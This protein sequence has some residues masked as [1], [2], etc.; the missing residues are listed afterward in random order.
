MKT[1]ALFPAV[2]ASL[3]LA[4]CAMQGLPSPLPSQFEASSSSATTEENAS[5]DVTDEPPPSATESPTPPLAVEERLLPGGLLEIGKSDA[6]LN[7]L[8]FTNHAC[9]YCERFNR[10]HLARVISDFV[11]QGKA[12]VTIVALPLGKYPQSVNA[13][14]MLVCAAK[15]G[16]GLSM[17]GLLF[18]LQG[19]LPAFT[20]ETSQAYDVPALQTCM[21]SPEIQSAVDQQKSWA[22]SLGVSL[23]PTLFLNGEKQTGLPEYADLRGWME[24]ALRDAE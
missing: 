3:L 14:K 7:L 12:R 16:K 21:A 17:N 23:L 15:Q 1:R 6:P 5:L 13:A 9:A 18:S 10:D 4:S 20:A 24:E 2:I 8:V 11:Q 22:H 19:K